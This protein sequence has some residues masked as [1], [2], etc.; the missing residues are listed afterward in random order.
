L[1]PDSREGF[2]SDDPLSPT[3]VGSVALFPFYLA[4]WLFVFCQCLAFLAVFECRG[5]ANR[6]VPRSPPIPALRPRSSFLPY[7]VMSERKFDFY[8]LLDY[9]SLWI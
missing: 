5:S 4:R 7:G 1:V 3:F 9:V 2:S 6:F 8:C